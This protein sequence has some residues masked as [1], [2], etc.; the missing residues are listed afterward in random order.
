[1][2][3][4]TFGTPIVIKGIAHMR[5]ISMGRSYGMPLPWWAV[6]RTKIVQPFPGATS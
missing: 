5:F 4:M 3:A 2:D 6:R 1:M